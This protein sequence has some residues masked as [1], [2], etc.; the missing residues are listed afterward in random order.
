LARFLGLDTDDIVNVIIPTPAGLTASGAT[1]SPQ[2]IDAPRWFDTPDLNRFFGKFDYNSLADG[3]IKILGTWE[4]D[5]IINVDVPLLNGL[6]TDGGKFN[7]KVRCHRL[8]K[9]AIVGAF[10]EIESN[11]RLRELVLFWS[12]SFVPRHIGRNPSRPLSPHSWGI[13]FDLNDEWNPWG[14]AGAPRGSKGSVVELVPIF[15]KYGFY[16]GGNFTK[17]DTMH[18]QFGRPV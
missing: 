7:G 12:G 4:A 9:D 10:S 1:V 13:G 14:E 11:P 8:I 2:S 6:A 3:S 16:W 18:F 15:E 5:N 17:R